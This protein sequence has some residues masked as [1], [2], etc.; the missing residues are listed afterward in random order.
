[1]TAEHLE[2]M[3]EVLLAARYRGVHGVGK[4]KICGGNRIAR[5]MRSLGVFNVLECFLE[6]YESG[7]CSERS[8]R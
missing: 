2:A 6:I 1:M 8:Q 3:P 4:S 5:R 7:C